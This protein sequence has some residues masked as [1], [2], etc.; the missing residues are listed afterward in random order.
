M[1]SAL[2]VGKGRAGK[3]IAQQETRIRKPRMVFPIYHAGMNGEA[4]RPENIRNNYT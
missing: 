3:L 2:K 1:G 4:S